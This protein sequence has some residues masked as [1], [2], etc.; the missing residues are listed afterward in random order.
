MVADGRISGRAGAG[1]RWLLASFG[2]CGSAVGSLANG[3][4]GQHGAGGV[5]PFCS[6]PSASSPPLAAWACGSSGS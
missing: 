1:V 3:G 4:Q 2:T 5:G 6:R